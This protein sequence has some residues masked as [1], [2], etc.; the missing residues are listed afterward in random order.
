MALYEFKDITTYSGSETSLPAEALSIN[1]K[2]IEN[3]IIGYKTLSVSGRELL[4]PEL[5]TAEVTKRDGL[6]YKGKHYP[7]RE[8]TIKY[9][10]LAE[11]VLAFRNKFNALNRILNVENAVLR[12]NDEMDKYFIGTLNSADDVEEGRN[13]IISS[14]SFLCPFPFKCSDLITVD[15]DSSNNFIFDYSG[16]VQT[17]PIFNLD[18]AGRCEVLTLS[19]SNGAILKFTDFNAG[20]KVEIHCDYP[21]IKVNG[22]YKHKKGS[23]DNDWEDFIIKPGKNIIK[24][25]VSGEAPTGKVKYRRCYI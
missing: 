3:E 17:Y 4:A 2:F 21:S 16:S 7:E 13:N 23:I 5:K 19:N 11:S 20:D 22:E 10:L 9:Q 18:F 14:F 12:F 8:I 24:I 15:V 25:T 6:L 1:G